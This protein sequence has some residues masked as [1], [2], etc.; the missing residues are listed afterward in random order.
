MRKIFIFAVIISMFLLATAAYADELKFNTIDAYV[1]G[2]LYSNIEK[3]SGKLEVNPGDLLQFT[4]NVEN[5]FPASQRMEIDGIDMTVTINDIKGTDDLYFEFREFGLD[6]DEETNKEVSFDIPEDVVPGDYI[7]EM[8]AAGTDDEGNSQK[9]SFVFP[10]KILRRQRDVYLYKPTI[11][12]AGVLC[13]ENVQIN[14]RLENRGRNAEAMTI[15]VLNNLLGIDVRDSDIIKAV[16]DNNILEKSITANV[17]EYVQGGMYPINVVVDYAGGQLLDSADLLVTCPSAYD[18]SKTKSTKLEPE[19]I[20]TGF[21]TIDIGGNDAG[22]KVSGFF[23][24]NRS[25]I[26]ML[27]GIGIFT[28]AVVMLL[29]AVIGFGTKKR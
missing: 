18:L 1:E 19:K 6:E 7:V 29:V 28:I 27:S 26:A 4:I 12:P 2:A 11:T 13:G 9:A 17:A 21:Q 5:E 15:T 20:A 25:E 3:D 14:L 8:K 23:L 10:L 24:R 16:P 22:K